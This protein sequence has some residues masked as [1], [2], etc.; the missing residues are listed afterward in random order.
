MEEVVLKWLWR[1]HL[2]G[3]YFRKWIVQEIKVRAMKNKE[4]PDTL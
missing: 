4:M 1:V 3:M 2:N